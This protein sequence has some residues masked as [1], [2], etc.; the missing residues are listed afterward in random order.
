MVDK[1][2]IGIGFL[3]QGIFASRFLVQWIASERAKKSVMPPA[4]WILSLIG[5]ILLF[6]YAIWRKDPVFIVGQG[7]GIFIYS[8]NLYFIYKERQRQRERVKS[9]SKLS[10]IQYNREC[11]PNTNT[12]LKSS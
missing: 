10:T 8:R 3:A 1:I 9:S 7:S 2:W 4:F 11:P 6:S 5:G 12:N